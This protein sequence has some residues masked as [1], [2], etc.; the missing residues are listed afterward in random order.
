MSKFL[1]FLI[2]LF[3]TVCFY[4]IG[5]SE[6]FKTRSN[7]YTEAYYLKSSNSQKPPI[8]YNHST[9]NEPALNL[10]MV[11]F[12]ADKNRWLFRSG[13]MLGTYAQKNLADEP[14]FWKQI[15]QLNIQVQIDSSNQL[16]LGI[17]PSHI[18]LESAKNMENDCFSRSYLAENSPYYESGLAL[19][20]IPMPNLLLRVLILTGWQHIA[21]FNPAV[22]MQLSISGKSGWRVN[23]SQFLGNEGRGTRVFLNNYAQLPISKKLLWT[24]GMDV[25]VESNKLWFGSLVFLTWK[26]NAKFRI[27][28]RTE[29]YSDPNAVIMPNAFTDT[30]NSLSMDYKLNKNFMLRSELK[31]SVKFDTEF[32]FGLIFI[33]TLLK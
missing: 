14:P 5:Q 21:K 12:F 16:M 23:S 29:F 10:G 1:F 33:S 13:I 15:Y 24:L 17:F 25:G 20:Y 19:N 30:A 28:G 8:F 32:L 27:S 2:L 18:G 9:I 31:K 26:P 7:V 22:G 6:K 3:Q 4:C 11:E